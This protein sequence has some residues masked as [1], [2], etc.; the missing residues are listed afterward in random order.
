MLGMGADRNLPTVLL[1]DEEMISRE[2]VATLLTMNGYTLHTASSG[3]ASLQLL[4]SGACHP[5]V[6]LVDL[7]AKNQNGAALIRDL[8]AHS[9]AA[10]YALGEGEPDEEMRAAVDGYLK[11]PVAP[12]ALQK[13]LSAHN[14]QPSPLAARIAAEPVVN[15][16]TLAQFRQLMSEATVREVYAAVAADLRKRIPTLEEA[17]Q[18]GNPQAV[19][20]IGHSIKGG[21]GMAGAMQAARVGALLEE[22]K[23]E[24]RNAN[25]LVG[26]LQGALERLEHMLEVAFSGQ[27][28]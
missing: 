6:I 3:A 8:R 15:P 20:Q 17:I 12:E 2:V 4:Q 14:R 27:A 26:E 9:K 7:P 1:I 21:C 16:E 19:R 25:A 5:Q 23:D 11:K 10:L 18:S 13:V 24:M 28:T 22:E